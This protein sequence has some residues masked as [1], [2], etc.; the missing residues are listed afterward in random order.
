MTIRY[1]GVT[2]Y[3]VEVEQFA[4]SPSVYL[5]NWALNDF[6]SSKEFC[7]TFKSVMNQKKGTLMVSW[8][9][10]FEAS[11]KRDSQ[12]F[13][14]ML[15]MI[16]S[17]DFAF[18]EVDPGIVIE[19][20]RKA[21]RAGKESPSIS[22]AADIALLK[23]YFEHSHDPLKPIRVSYIFSQLREGLL[24]F[25]KLGKSVENLSKNIYPL[26]LKAR[27]DPIA[28]KRA[29]RR[30]KNRKK[31]PAKGFPYTEEL[32]YQCLDYIVINKQMK[33]P[34][35]EWLD[36][37]NTIVPVAYFDFVLL[38]S[39]WT[40]FIRQTIFTYPDIAMLYGKDGITA[41]FSKLS[42][43]ESSHPILSSR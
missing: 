6:S 13:E 37:F 27:N 29:K 7:E 1:K 4:N 39:R 3:G 32:Y 15:G 31:R 28:F 23:N 41:F 8:V 16:D 19:R 25:D 10:L 20:E 2:E 43:F 38:D 42:S 40:N 17:M 36:V 21:R 22:P 5:D 24:E 34:N 18:T 9:T 33:M 11:K 26:V 12:R 35:K 30:Y 14:K